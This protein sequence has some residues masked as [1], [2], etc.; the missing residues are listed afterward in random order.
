MTKFFE[1]KFV[2][3]KLYTPRQIIELTASDDQ[4]VHKFLRRLRES[5]RPFNEYMGRNM[6]PGSSLNAVIDATARNVGGPS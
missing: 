2:D 3:E 5:G 1:T 6:Y 4:W